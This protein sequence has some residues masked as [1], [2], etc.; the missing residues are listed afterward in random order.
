MPALCAL[1]FLGASAPLSM[2]ACETPA[3]LDS[4]LA[5]ASQA[6]VLD[7][8]GVNPLLCPPVAMSESWT[9]GKL[10]L[11]DAPESPSSRG[12]LYEDA[13]LKA[14]D[15]DNRIFLYHANGSAGSLKFTVLI[16][17]LGS[18][19]GALR[20]RR[21]GTAGPTT[22]YLYG[23]KIALY[24]WLNSVSGDE[25]EVPPSATVQLD[26]TF[27]SIEATPRFM[28]HGIWDYSFS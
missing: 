21:K 8:L 24:R 11:S 16:T 4:D 3:Q 26:S 15:L 27:D 13:T 14:T 17:N 22:D 25:V 12:K 23:G 18:G 28:M 1:A 5:A 19:P 10:I 9:G 20:I 6:D 7:L 2:D